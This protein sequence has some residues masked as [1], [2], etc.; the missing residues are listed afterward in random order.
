MAGLTAIVYGSTGLIGKEL[1][2]LLIGSE[3]YTN[4]ILPVRKGQNTFTSPKIKEIVVNFDT[5]IDFRENLKADVA[6]LCLGTTMAK[7]KSKEAFYKVDFTY[8]AEAAKLACENGSSHILLVSSLGADTKSM[9][10][11]SKVK[12]ETEQYIS[13][14]SCEKVSI[15]RPSLLL[16][17]RTEKRFGEALAIRFFRSFSFLFVGPLRMYKGIEAHDVAKAMLYQSLFPQASK[18]EIFLSHQIQ[19][20]ADKV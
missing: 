12:G 8:S 17:N 10:Y 6:F 11:Y 7:A 5:L 4:I 16:G 2:S 14:L 9:V 20:I 3:K 15:F 19:M 1:V 13:G 18:R